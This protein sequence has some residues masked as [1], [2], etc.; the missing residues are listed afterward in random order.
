MRGL[1]FAGLLACA[2]GLG[3]TQP[4]TN[5][6]THTWNANSFAANFWA[7][8]VCIGGTRQSP[9]DIV[10]TAAVI[11]KPDVGAIMSTGFENDAPANWLMNG[12]AGTATTPTA[13]ELTLPTPAFIS[14]GPLDE[15]LVHFKIIFIFVVLTSIFPAISSPTSSSTG[16]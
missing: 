15:R 6:Q 13:I 4:Y 5:S 2:H 7:A 10:S 12:V 16:L 1:I 3:D 11:A 9:I 8:D 14:G